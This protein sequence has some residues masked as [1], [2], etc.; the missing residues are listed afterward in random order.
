MNTINEL[1]IKIMAYFIHNNELTEDLT[2]LTDEQWQKIYDFS[3][4]HSLSPAI[5]EVIKHNNSFEKLI[6]Y[7][8]PSIE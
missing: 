4:L 3:K 5:Y 7:K 1:F 2:F 8:I 6:S